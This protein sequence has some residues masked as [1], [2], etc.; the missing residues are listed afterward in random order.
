MRL[1]WQYYQRRP[2]PLKIFSIC[3]IM[4]VIGCIQLDQKKWHLLVA[5]LVINGNFPQQIIN[6]KIIQIF[7]LIIQIVY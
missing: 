7:V 2:A 5:G 6:E 3:F 1:S 4:G